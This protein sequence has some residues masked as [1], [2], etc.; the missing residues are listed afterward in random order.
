MD[1]LYLIGAIGKDNEL[2]YNNDLIWRI[3]EDLL[4]FQ[5]ITKDKIT[6]LI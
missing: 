5:K 4:Y 6:S 1:N 2:G 3:K